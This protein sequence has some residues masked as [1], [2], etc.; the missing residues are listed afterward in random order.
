MDLGSGKRAVGL[1][2]DTGTARVIELT[3]SA[4]KPK[5]SAMSSIALPDKAVEEGMILQPEEVGE[6]LSRLWSSGAVKERRVLLGVSNQGVLVRY[7]T[8][9]KVPADKLNSVIKFHAQEYLPIPLDTVVMDYL[10]IGE[11]V[12]EGQNMLEI[13]LVAARRDMLKGFMESLEIARLEPVDIDVSALALMWVLPQSAK[14]RAVA[15]INVANGLSNI[16]ISAQGSPRLARLVSVKLGDIA[17]QFGYSLNEVLN[18]NTAGL[19]QQG[20][21]VVEWIERLGT[22]IRSSI[23]YYQDQ[24][25]STAVEA[26]VINGR[27]ARLKQI[28]SRLEQ[29]LDLPVRIINPLTGIATSAA[30]AGTGLEPVEYAISAG[31]ARRCLEG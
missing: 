2:I 17:E 6:A 29:I 19:K 22:E 21:L 18:I 5:L 8:I 4:K 31:L 30:I 14:E 3:G 20:A 12:V 15:V 16:L 27:G 9:P 25:G 13:L 28:S 26:I 11:T 10:V 7:A 23:A 1:E 24:D